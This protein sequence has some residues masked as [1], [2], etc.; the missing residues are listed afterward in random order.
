MNRYKGHNSEVGAFGM[1]ETAS[2]PQPPC[3]NGRTLVLA[4][5]EFT[6]SIPSVVVDGIAV[7]RKNS[8]MVHANLIALEKP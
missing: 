4:A 3:A 8:A 5:F 6:S 7:S 1:S 2:D